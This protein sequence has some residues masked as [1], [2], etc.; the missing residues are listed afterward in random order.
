MYVAVA[1]LI[2]G[3]ALLCP[4]L[5]IVLYLMLFAVAVTAFVRFYEEPKLLAAHG[6]SYQRY[7]QAVPPAA[8]LAASHLTVHGVTLPGRAIHVSGHV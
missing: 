4:I 8:Q 5:A 6:P 3:Q 7:H 2:G 1:S